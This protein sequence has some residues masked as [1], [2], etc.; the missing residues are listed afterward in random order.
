MPQ[1][2]SIP[3]SH[4]PLDSES[5]EWVKSVPDGAISISQQGDRFVLHAS[6][7]LQERFEDLVERRKAGLLTPAENEQYEA[8][9]ELDDVLSWLN[10]LLRRQHRGS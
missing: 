9:C 7:T 2:T 5:V 8:I 3:E 4:G 10:R 6:C 1:N